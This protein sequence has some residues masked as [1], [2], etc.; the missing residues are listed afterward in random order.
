MGDPPGPE[1][2]LTSSVRAGPG[3]PPLGPARSAV[4]AVLRQSDQAGATLLAGPL[5]QRDIGRDV[6]VVGAGPQ[7]GDLAGASE[8]REIA[9]ADAQPGCGLGGRDKSQ[10]PSQGRAFRVVRLFCTRGG[11]REPARQAGGRLARRPWLGVHGV[12]PAVV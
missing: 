3:S 11:V 1:G 8:A 2:E 9:A 5:R 7:G 12:A 10:R 4:D 6:V